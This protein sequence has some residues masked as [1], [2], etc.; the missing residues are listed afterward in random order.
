[1]KYSILSPI[2]I[3]ISSMF[4]EIKHICSDLD[5]LQKVRDYQENQNHNQSSKIDY[6][7]KMK[8]FYW[9]R[10]KANLQIFKVPDTLKVQILEKFYWLHS[11]KEEPTISLQV[12]SGGSILLPHKDENRSCSILISINDNKSFTNFYQ[13]KTLENQ[14]VPDP[15]NIILKQSVCFGIG[16]NWFF[17]NRSVHSVTL[18][19]PIRI[20][21]SIGFDK[22]EFK[23]LCEVAFSYALV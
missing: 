18:E 17:D 16:E 21:L 14:M 22:V 13:E 4:E 9:K 23:K 8:K 5:K 6:L 3:D 2:Q 19:Q 12:I 1:M 7:D 11:L 10:T 15:E 20:N